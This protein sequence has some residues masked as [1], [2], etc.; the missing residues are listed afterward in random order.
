MAKPKH[1]ILTEEGVITQEALLA[2]ARGRLSPEE[3]AQIDR[4]LRDDPFAQEALDGIRNSAAAAGIDTAVT[5]INSRLREKAGMREKKRK[6]VEIHWATYAYAAVIVGVLIGLGFVMVHFIQQNDSTIAMTKSTPQAEESTP[7]AVQNM[8]TTALVQDTTHLVEAPPATVAADTM[9]MLAQN[10]ATLSTTSGGA[11]PVAG[12]AQTPG[13]QPAAKT[14]SAVTTSAAV[15]EKKVIPATAD[16]VIASK[17]AAPASADHDDRKVEMRNAAQDVDKNLT[18]PV[19]APATQTRA[20]AK[21]EKTD[22]TVADQMKAARALFDA[23]DFKEAGKKYNKVLSDQPENIDALFFGGICEYKNGKLK[24]AEKNF[25]KL[26]KSGQY[27]DGSKWYKA[28]V[29]LDRGKRDD[30]KQLLE[31]LSNTPN[32]YRDRAV[33]KYEEIQ[34]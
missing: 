16:Q 11:V 14:Q 27:V 12:L 4:L 31:Q 28:N 22:A 29:L 6:G 10:T 34:K 25:D 23:G 19:A 24:P 3:V 5:A 18:T 30:A 1:I 20:E 8:D 13:A 26:L 32:P 7:V 33:K 17:P 9:K 15:A 21:K 2:Y